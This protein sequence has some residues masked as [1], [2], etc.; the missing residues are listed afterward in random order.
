MHGSNLDSV[1][2]NLC[3]N[4]FHIIQIILCVS[5]RLQILYFQGEYKCLPQKQE[6]M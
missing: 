2:V 1:L 6:E 3:Y 4:M 5:L